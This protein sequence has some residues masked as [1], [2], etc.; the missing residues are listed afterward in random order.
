MIRIITASV[1]ASV[2][3][4][5]TA[6]AQTVPSTGTPLS[7]SLT[8]EAQ[9]N[10]GTAQL[11]YK[12]GQTQGALAALQEQDAA[13]A[14][15]WKRYV[16]GIDSLLDAGVIRKKSGELEAVPEATRDPKLPPHAQP[17]GGNPVH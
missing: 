4:A 1:L 11:L 12:L 13:L 16:E 2:L 6:D 10:I 15:Y 7:N 14:A 3:L 9:Q 17:N 5:A 8:N